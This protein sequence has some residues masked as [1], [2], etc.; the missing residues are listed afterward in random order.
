MTTSILALIPARGAS[1]R[2]P[3]K[4]VRPLGG[5]PLIGWTIRAAKES[6]VLERIVVSTDDDEIAAIARSEGA[7]VPFMRPAEL[8]QDD[9]SSEAVGEHALHSL[10]GQDGY[11]PEYILLLQP[12]S[13]LRTAD[14]IRSLIALREKN[15][16]TAVVSFR[17]GAAAPELNGALYLVR[18][19]VFLEEKTFFPACALHYIM[20]P[21]RSIDID[22]EADWARVEEELRARR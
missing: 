2:L 21:E 13:P 5:V 17:G 7:E 9:S 4:N 6:G 14:D 12:T 18:T 8:A 20:P 1:K 22:T 19:D 10:A 3:R 11:E 15:A 16:A